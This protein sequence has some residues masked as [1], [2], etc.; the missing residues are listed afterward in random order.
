MFHVPARDQGLAHGPLTAA[1]APR[2]I[3]GIA[4]RGPQGDNLA[5]TGKAG[6]MVIAKVTGIHL[7]DGC[8]IEG[9]HDVTRPG[10]LPRLGYPDDGAV[11]TLSAMSRPE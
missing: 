5:L 8:L 3:A 9:R 7:R 6:L 4:T 11:E 2:P 1:V 10:L